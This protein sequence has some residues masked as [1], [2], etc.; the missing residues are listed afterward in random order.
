MSNEETEVWLSDSPIDVIENARKLATAA[1]EDQ[2]DKAGQPYAGHAERVAERASSICQEEAPH[3]T[4]T[5]VAAAW[6]HDVVEDSTLT[7]DGLRYLE[8]PEP[9]VRAVEAVTKKD[10]E[11][12][13]A[14]ACRIAAI[15]AAVIV[16]RADLADNTD[17]ERLALLDDETRLRLEAKYAEFRRVL[18]D[19][20]SASGAVVLCDYW[21]PDISINVSARIDDGKLI[22]AGHDLGPN[23]R[24]IWGDSDYE[25]W[26]TFEAAGIE[27]L[28]QHLGADNI[29]GHLALNF[30]GPDG[31]S[32]LRHVCDAARIP[33]EFFTYV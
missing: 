32:R 22:L 27:A 16:K 11:P 33:Y 9:V 6:L 5:V 14:Y 8:F 29:L 13:T 12:A 4:E 25:Y 10:G 31:M 7:A 18:G 20:L 28:R 21:R 15:P 26:L 3:L 1:H 17:P 19:A 23:V 24:R 2:V 30:T